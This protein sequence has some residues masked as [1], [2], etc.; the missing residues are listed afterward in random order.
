[1][2][3]D[4]HALELLVVAPVLLT[5]V[6]LWTVVGKGEHSYG[7]SSASEGNMQGYQG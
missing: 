5:N 3:G 7:W 1:M 4:P 2:I 6:L